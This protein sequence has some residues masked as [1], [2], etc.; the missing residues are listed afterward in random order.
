MARKATF[1][2]GG[3]VLHRCLGRR[4]SAWYDKD[5]NL[6]DHAL[7]DKLGRSRKASG[8]DVE[9]LMRLGKVYRPRSES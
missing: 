5:G 8:K 1:P 3:F 6:L 2:N 7:I 4:I 9:A